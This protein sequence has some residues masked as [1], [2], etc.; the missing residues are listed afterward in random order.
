MPTHI[1]YYAVPVPLGVAAVPAAAIP[2]APAALPAPPWVATPW[3]VVPPVPLNTAQMALALKKD[4]DPGGLI[5]FFNLGGLALLFASMYP[6]API[7]GQ[8]ML[9]ASPNFAAVPGNWLSVLSQLAAAATSLAVAEY[10]ENYPYCLSMQF[11]K[12]GAV[13]PGPGPVPAWPAAYWASIPQ[14]WRV[15]PVAPGLMPDY[16]IARQVGPAGQFEFST[17]EAKGRGAAVDQATYPRYAAMKAQAQNANIVSNPD[18]AGGVPP[19]QLT[20]KILS[21]VAIRPKMIGDKTRA[22]RC[23]W[24]NHRDPQAL[25]TVSDAE[26]LR[27][28]AASYAVMLQNSGFFRLAD[29]I[30]ACIR[31]NVAEIHA[32]PPSNPTGWAPSDFRLTTRGKQFLAAHAE[33][34]VLGDCLLPMGTFDVIRRICSSLVYGDDAARRAVSELLWRCAAPGEP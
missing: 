32:A 5:P 12:L 14:A 19:P 7:G 1:V 4:I 17:M 15:A 20:R 2:I 6:S 29:A 3:G 34:L 11:C 22:L 16:V 18:V 26:G 24:T 23:R 9:I 28:V 27:F 13:G 21:L 10:I 31:L 25:R 33:D 8:D 30:A